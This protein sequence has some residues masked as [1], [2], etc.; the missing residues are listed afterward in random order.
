MKLAPAKKDDPGRLPM[1]PYPCA[2]LHTQGAQV[3]LS[4][5]HSHPRVPTVVLPG[6]TTAW[7][8]AE[9][10]PGEGIAAI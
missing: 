10:D 4:I 1:T 9:S 5:H 8:L 7:T 6:L 2:F 3:A